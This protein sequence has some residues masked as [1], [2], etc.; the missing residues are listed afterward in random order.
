[1]EIKEVSITKITLL[2]LVLIGSLKNVVGQEWVHTSGPPPPFPFSG[3]T[4]DTNDRTLFV[5]RGS[6]GGEMCSGKTWLSG[7]QLV[8][9]KVPYGGREY[10]LSYFEVL[11]APSWADYELTW[12]ESTHSWGYLPDGAVSAGPGIYVGR[13][14]QLFGGY[15]LGQVNYDELGFFY[16]EDGKEYSKKINYEVLTI[17]SRP[18]AQYEILNIVYD[19]SKATQTLSA[20]DVILASKD[21][22]NDT[23]YDTTSSLSMDI[24]ETKTSQW[25]E[26]GSLEMHTG[27]SV[28]VS[29]GIPYIGKLTG[30][31]EAGLSSTYSYTYGES[32]TSSVTTSHEISVDLPQYSDTRV[33]IIAKTANVKVPYTATI[34]VV[35]SN[36]YTYVM[37]GV[38]GLYTDAHHTAFQTTVETSAKPSTTS[39]AA[40]ASLCGVMMFSTLFIL[41]TGMLAFE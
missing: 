10:S 37:D 11:T 4:V 26:T 39:G 38:K 24:T 25:S 15:L 2:T 35:F 17:M 6:V 29:A 9:C 31:W 30:K 16:T 7:G 22:T 8:S 3:S 23:P 41:W 19:L 13:Y 1:M 28:S 33:S 5:C 36:G 18:I 12:S 27:I 32:F 20:D 40:T 14:E 34:R 21:V